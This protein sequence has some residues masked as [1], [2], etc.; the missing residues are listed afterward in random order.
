MA[1]HI[2]G[3]DITTVSLVALC[4][5]PVV[6]MVFVASRVRRHRSP[7]SRPLAADWPHTSGTV[8]SATVQVNRHGAGR[9]QTPIVLYAYQVDGRFFQGS[10][11]RLRGVAEASGA[12]ARYPAGACVTVY[13]DPANP[14][15]CALER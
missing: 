10:R 15:L 6:T 7:A 3:I 8:L 1:G 9:K 14:A 13:Y 2:G 4:V 5:A 11:V 12:L